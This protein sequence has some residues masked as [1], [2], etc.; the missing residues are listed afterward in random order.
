[1]HPEHSGSPVVRVGCCNGDLNAAVLP[2]LNQVP[3]T[4]DVA[5]GSLGRAG[6]VSVALGRGA[7]VV[8]T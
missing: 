6:C 1:M 3:I 4:C 5:A 7:T 8:P 2:G